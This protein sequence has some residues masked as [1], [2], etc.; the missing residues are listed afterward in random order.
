MIK[1]IN[2]QT[3]A[4]D[5]QEKQMMVT[6]DCWRNGTFKKKQP[7]PTTVN[8]VLPGVL[9]LKQDSWHWYFSRLLFWTL[10]VPPVWKEAAWPAPAI[11]KLPRNP[12]RVWG[13]G[14][15]HQ[16][17][18]LFVKLCTSRAPTSYSVRSLSVLASGLSI[19]SFNRFFSD[20]SSEQH[21]MRI[22]Y[23]LLF[24]SHLGKSSRSRLE[25]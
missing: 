6:F 3:H 22:S 24:Q 25:R 21:A 19:L 17:S 16:L 13:G 18:P 14:T 11:C 1:C 12:L 5:R 9:N 23:Q 20:A 10:S 4:Y 2:I 7:K 8:L 15:P